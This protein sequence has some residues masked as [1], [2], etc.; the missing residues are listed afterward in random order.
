M[1][2]KI[3]RIQRAHSVSWAVLSA[4]AGPVTG[5]GLIPNKWYGIGISSTFCAQLLAFATSIFMSVEF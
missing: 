1:S 3:H 5:R 4:F 2:R